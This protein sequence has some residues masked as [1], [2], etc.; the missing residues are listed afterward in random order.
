MRQLLNFLRLIMNGLL[1]LPIE[2]C[3]CLHR[4]TYTGQ[5]DE[6]IGLGTIS[7]T[8]SRS[9]SVKITYLDNVY[10]QLQTVWLAGDNLTANIN[11]VQPMTTATVYYYNVQSLDV[12]G[13]PIV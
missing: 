7:V 2:W 6:F 5:H 8:K 11:D 10:T 13:T 4:K 12:N 1:K 3:N 9:G